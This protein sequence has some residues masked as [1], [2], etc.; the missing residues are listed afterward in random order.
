MIVLSIF[1][2][3][4]DF[5]TFMKC[6]T[7]FRFFKYLFV[8]FPE[9]CSKISIFFQKNGPERKNKKPERRFLLLPAPEINGNY[10]PITDKTYSA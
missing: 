4:C 9:S 10:K 8:F 5:R 6:I 3:L 2:C 7:F 1:F